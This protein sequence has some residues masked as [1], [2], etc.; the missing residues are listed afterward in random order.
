MRSAFHAPH[1]PHVPRSLSPHS[2]NGMSVYMVGIKGTGMSA[3]AELCAQSGA[4][5]S[6][7]DIAEV[8][9]TDE[10]LKRNGIAVHEGFSAENVPEHADMLI[11]SSAY[12]PETHPELLRA[13]EMGYKP[14][15]FSEA[16][17]QY[18]SCMPFAAVSGVH[19]KTTTTAITALIARELGL[20]GQVL[21]GSAL[22]NLPN[23]PAPTYAAGSA[24]PT[25]AAGSAAP[26]Y[27]AGSAVYRGGND[28]FIAET[29]EYRRNFL[30]FT[31][32]YLLVT[33][34]EAD[35]L[36]YFRDENDVQSAFEELLAR[37]PPAGTLIYCADDPGAAA[38]A[39]KSRQTRPD[40]E[41]IAYGFQADGRYGIRSRRVEN[42]AQRFSLRGIDTPFTLNYPGRHAVLDAVAAIILLNQ[43]YTSTHGRSAESPY[44]RMSAALTHYTGTKR[45]SELIAD[46][47]GIRIMDDYAHHPTAIQTTL[48]GYREFFPGRRLIVDFMSHTYSRTTALLEDFAASF[49]CADLLIL[50]D[51]YASAREPNPGNIHGDRL[52][53]E[54]RKTHP[55]VYYI[56]NFEKAALFVKERLQKTDIFVTM[57]AGNNWQIGKR[58]TEMLESNV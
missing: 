56:P 42:G 1:A 8:F 40:I 5:V 2:L 38:L 30:K 39:R 9:Y 47:D 23:L 51:I 26:T 54:I 20:T 15:E 41:P 44:P 10:I 43:I 49:A 16:L 3:L 11:Y 12:N 36:D 48:A 35:H 57:G 21:V 46:I 34:I 22:P 27:A 19:G 7:S 32:K 58:L 55:H 29:C 24:A 33:S 50:N 4:L 28:F 53:R 14:L 31:P 6:G 17:A 25:Y 45:R 13:R 52:Y 18:A 37:V